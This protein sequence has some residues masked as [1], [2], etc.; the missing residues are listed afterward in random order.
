MQGCLRRI[1]AVGSYGSTQTLSRHSRSNGV[2]CRGLR[3]RYKLHVAA[4]PSSQ[5]KII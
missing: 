3:C 1:H 4:V 5:L 2:Q